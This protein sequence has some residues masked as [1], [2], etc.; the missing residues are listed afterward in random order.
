MKKIHLLAIACGLHF[1]LMVCSLAAANA[2][3]EK[4]FA[5]CD[6]RTISIKN[7]NL[8]VQD[9]YYRQNENIY[10]AI[11]EVKNLT[12][13]GKL[14]VGTVIYPNDIQLATTGT[15]MDV[16][17]FL[18]RNC[19]SP[20]PSSGYPVGKGENLIFIKI[21]DRQTGYYQVYTLSIMGIG[22]REA[23]AAYYKYAEPTVIVSDVYSLRVA[24][25]V[26]QPGQVIGITKGDYYVFKEGLD[27]KR[28][29]LNN[30]HNVV[31]RSI[32][33]EFEDVSLWGSGFHKQNKQG[34]ENYTGAYQDARPHNEMLI[35]GEGSSDIVIY[36]ITVRESNANGYK[37]NG[38]NERNITLDR[39]RAMDVNEYMVKGS[40]PSNDMFVY[41][42]TI[43][44]CHFENTKQPYHL[45]QSDHTI[46]CGGYVGAIDIM[47]TR[48]SYIADNTFVNI[49]GSNKGDVDRCQCFGAIGF[50][51]QG[52][53]EDAIV[54]RN[55]IYNCGTGIMLGIQPT[56][57]SS[58]RPPVNRGIVRNNIIFTSGGW[59]AIAAALTNDVQIYNNTIVKGYDPYHMD[60]GIRDVSGTTYPSTGLVIKNNIAGSFLLKGNTTVVTENNLLQDDYEVNDYFMN[61]PPSHLDELQ[62][63]EYYYTHHVK[64]ED[65]MLTEKAIKAIGKGI[66]LPSLVD[67]DFFRKAR[68]EAPD[69]GAAAIVRN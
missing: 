28:V 33:G 58:G 60:R 57:L 21:K 52:G 66:A 68:G 17:F 67:E 55:F 25:E 34:A 44:N 40:G 19:L 47:N 54:E 42:L 65:F 35:I 1:F 15:D 69:I 9:T 3:Q 18:N 41:N 2:D 63:M 39:C 11:V 14:K 20:F 31:F 7:V 51:G 32:S 12:V 37:I 45:P 64:P 6:I 50:W 8:N 49:L 53:H 13:S 62:L 48:V 38:T 43:V 23:D 10:A 61:A 56:P 24:F 30:K 36:G 16:S 27:T 29:E 22:D 26:A 5:N 4:F 59:D 46:Q